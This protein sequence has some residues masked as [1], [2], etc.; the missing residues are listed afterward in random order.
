MFSIDEI[1]DI[2]A[3]TQE[4]VEKQNEINSLLSGQLTEVNKP[5]VSLHNIDKVLPC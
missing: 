2:L 1:E 5:N 4:A 3:D